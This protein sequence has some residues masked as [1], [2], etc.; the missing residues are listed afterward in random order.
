MWRWR[1]SW[2]TDFDIREWAHLDTTLPRWATLAVME[3][4]AFY[5]VIKANLIKV[6]N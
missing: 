2:C 6:I 1:I 3:E 5:F 4:A